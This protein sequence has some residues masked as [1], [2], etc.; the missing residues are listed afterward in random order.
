VKYVGN[1]QTPACHGAHDLVRIRCSTQRCSYGCH[2]VIDWVE[3]YENG[4]A[5]IKHCF[6][7][8]GP[9]SAVVLCDCL[10][11]V[12]KRRRAAGEPELVPGPARNLSCPSPQRYVGGYLADEGEDVVEIR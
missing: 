4:R 1:Y 6:W 9:R 5:H 3:L 11:C 2:G 12:N 10:E 7:V 8:G